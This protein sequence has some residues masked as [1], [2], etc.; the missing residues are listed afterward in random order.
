MER[1][2]HRRDGDWHRHRMRHWTEVL[3]LALAA[4]GSAYSQDT[5]KAGT[6]VTY[7]DGALRLSRDVSVRIGA[8]I[9]PSLE[10]QQ[11]L[12]TAAQWGAAH[13]ILVQ[14]TPG[15]I[16]MIEENL[17]LAEV[18]RAAGGGGVKATR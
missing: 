2:G 12:P 16:T 1:P 5:L 15:D 17:L 11:D 6:P 7:D 3:M 13:G 14:E 18:K 9:Q 4:G 8:V 10:L